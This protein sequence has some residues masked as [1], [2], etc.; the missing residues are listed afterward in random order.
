VTLLNNLSLGDREHGLM[1]NYAN[2]ADVAGNLVRGGTKK[3]L[4]IYNA[5][6]NLIWEQPLRRLRHRHPLHR[7]LRTQR[8]DRQRLYRQP[9]QVK[10]VGTRNMEWS[11]EG[12]AISGPTIPPLT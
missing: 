4:F 5:H 12:A 7:R 1:L 8:A 2:N 11:F 3:C 9:E 10:Y 6:K